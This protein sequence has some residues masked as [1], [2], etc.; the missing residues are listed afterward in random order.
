[1]KLLDEY[2]CQLY[3]SDEALSYAVY[4]DRVDVVDYLLCN[5]KYSLNNEYTIEFS[6][7]RRHSQ[8]TLLISACQNHSVK[9]VE[10]LVEHGANPNT[11]RYIDT[12][13]SAI[14]LAINSDI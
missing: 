9:M 7:G 8:Q 5:H 10:L 11:G 6:G 12:C 3:R 14:N 13:S 2:G 4:L 1:M